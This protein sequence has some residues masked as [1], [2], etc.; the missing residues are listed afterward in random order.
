[1]VR[2]V[3]GDE[4]TW[5]YT[6]TNTGHQA[7]TCSLCLKTFT[8]GSLGGASTLSTWNILRDTAEPTNQF[9]EVPP[10]PGEGMA[11]QISKA[12]IIIRL[13]G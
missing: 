10:P 4:Q 9:G 12:V 1:M 13:Q 8:L 2:S 3:K 7:A 11:A 6:L 5:Q